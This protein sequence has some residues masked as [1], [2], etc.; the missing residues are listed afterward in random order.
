MLLL[1]VSEHKA[2][3]PEVQF[4]YQLIPVALP[5]EGGWKQGWFVVR[6]G[7]MQGKLSDFFFQE[8]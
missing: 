1:F 2:Q 3:V 6:V 8:Y 4:P 7:S 5:E